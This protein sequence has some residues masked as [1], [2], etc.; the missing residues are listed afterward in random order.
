[1][2]V[3]AGCATVFWLVP[4]P[5]VAVFGAEPAVAGLAMELLAVAAVFQVLDAVAMTSLSAL[6]G[7]GDTRFAM[8]A[9]VLGTWLVKLPAAWWLAVGLGWGAWGAW[10]ALTLE[11]AAVSV[12][13]VWR[14]N[15]ERWLTMGVPHVEVAA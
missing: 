13:A 8:V 7:A 5:L 2:G 10:I 11:V 1:M 15:G 3:M 14:L 12:L 4:G 6:N 9:S